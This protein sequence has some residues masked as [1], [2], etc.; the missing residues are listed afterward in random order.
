MN[1][2]QIML[3]GGAAVLGGAGIAGYAATRT[4]SM[5]AYAARMSELR[6]PLAEDS[7]DQELVRYATLA[8]NGHNTQPWRFRR[9]GGA[10]S[11]R[12]D[13]T[14]R[15]PVVDPDDHHLYASLGCAA[16]NLALAA[17]A[18]GRGGALHFDAAG[19][20]GVMFSPGSVSD[21]PADLFA[22]IPQRQSTRAEYDGQPVSASDLA[23][24]EDAARMP[25]VNLVLIT[26]PNRLGRVRDLVVAGNTA[27]MADP[28]FVRELKDWLRFSPRQALAA[29][30]GLFTGAS[31]NPVAPAWL[32]GTMFDLFFTA[33]AENEKYARQM[34]SSAGVAVFLAERDDPE[35]WVLAGRAC[36]RFALK[37]TALGL[38][39]AFINQ[40]V[41]V[42][43]LRNDMAQLA[44]MPGRRPDIVMRFGS[45]P[46]LPYSPRR[47]VEAVLTA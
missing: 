28:A 34:A 25:G 35:H 11:I 31:G 36:Q 17:A 42:A 21:H 24:L 7:A 39:H 46:L 3:A 23:Q 10:I 6:R 41:E 22:A 37:A 1:R 40:P 45:G 2:R 29:G 9:E 16:E 4:G 12:P 27:Q 8:A 44:G 5:E 30:D 26:E 14:R 15:T 18:Q 38:R 32:G 43:G 13:P 33:D 20:G 19:E 47:P